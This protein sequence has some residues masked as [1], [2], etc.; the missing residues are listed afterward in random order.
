MA[1]EKF[2]NK[3]V[4]TVKLQSANVMDNLVTTIKILLYLYV[5]KTAEILNIS[6]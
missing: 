6:E 4:E 1:L 3:E 2:R 5:D